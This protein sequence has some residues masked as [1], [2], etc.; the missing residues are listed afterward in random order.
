[1]AA[2]HHGENAVRATLYR[3]VQVIGQLRDVPESLGQAGIEFHRVRGRE[4]DAVDAVDGGH[5]VDQQGEVRFAAVMHGPEIGIH[6]LAQQVDLA[7]ALPRQPGAFGHHVIQRAADFLAA[8]V[9]HHA[10]RAVL[11]ATFHY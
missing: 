7:H 3:Q 1:M 2:L 11:A 9:R 8:G 4:A 5:V 6:V 10:E